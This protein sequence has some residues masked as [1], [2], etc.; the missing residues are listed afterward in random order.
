MTV[1]L[2]AVVILSSKTRISK[3]KVE[4]AVQADKTNKTRMDSRI[5]R[6]DKAL[7]VREVSNRMVTKTR[8]ETVVVHLQ[9]RS[10]INLA[11]TETSSLVAVLDNK[12]INRNPVRMVDKISNLETDSRTVRPE[13]RM[14]RINKEMVAD[15]LAIIS[16]TVREISKAINSKVLAKMDR[17]SRMVKVRRTGKTKMVRAAAPVNKMVRKDKA[18]ATEKKRLQFIV[19]PLAWIGAQATSLLLSRV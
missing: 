15:S 4:V 10:L 7:V 19:C 5:S 18:R 14:V 3:D 8:M 13:I 16:K 17:I 1:V 12:E 9:L 11:M 6:T 2:E